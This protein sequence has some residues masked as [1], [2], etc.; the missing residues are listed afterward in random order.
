MGHGAI[1]PRKEKEVEEEGEE[2]NRF[3]HQNKYEHGC[4]VCVCVCVRR[5]GWSDDASGRWKKEESWGEKGDEHKQQARRQDQRLFRE[6]REVGG[7]RKHKALYLMS[8]CVCLCVCVCVC[9]YVL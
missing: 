3:K 5:D 2:R 7:K 1:P 4:C 8:V 6:V 9:V